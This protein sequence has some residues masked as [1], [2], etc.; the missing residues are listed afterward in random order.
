M[1]VKKVKEKIKKLRR[2]AAAGPDGIGPTLLQE[3]VN[4]VASPLA[5]VMRKTLE[6][7]SMPADWQ[8]ANVSPIF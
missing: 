3:L 4:E 1:T 6:D 7:G 8:T 5:T 2:G